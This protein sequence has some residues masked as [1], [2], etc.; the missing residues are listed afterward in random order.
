MR[1]FQRVMA[2]V[3]ATLCVSGACGQELPKVKVNFQMKAA[4]YA[5][6]F[7]NAADKAVFESDVANALAAVFNDEIGF[8][9]FGTGTGAMNRLHIVLDSRVAGNPDT[10]FVETWFQIQINREPVQSTFDF[11]DSKLFFL[12]R[13][14]LDGL[15]IDIPAV[16][17]T[18]LQER[19]DELIQT[20]FSQ[21]SLADKVIINGDLRFSVLPFSYQDLRIGLD[22]VFIL[23]TQQGG[24]GMSM[25]WLYGTRQTASHLSMPYS[26]GIFATEG[27][28][29]IP[30]SIHT[31]LIAVRRDEGEEP[32]KR[33]RVFKGSRYDPPDRLDDDP[34][35]L[36][37]EN[38]S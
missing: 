18:R 1:I 10:P 2:G 20:L 13:G 37:V 30:H 24:G 32:I 17:R 7:L 8:L 35:E 14:D 28:P 33:L 9:R 38:P 36:D 25:H 31:P 22:A 11:H 34:A 6:R 4:C 12:Q 15:L 29:L 23:E 19:R 26:V 27:T 5:H 16:I 21:I 3:T